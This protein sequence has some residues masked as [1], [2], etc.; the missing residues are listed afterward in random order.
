M[1]P[2]EQLKGI[3]IVHPTAGSPIPSVGGAFRLKRHG[4]LLTIIASWEDASGWDHVSVSLPHRCPT[5]DEMDAV[6]RRFFW[7]HEVVMQLHPAEA[8][9]LSLHP[10]CLHLWRPHRVAIPLPPKE[11]V[12]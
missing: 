1:R 4:T 7:P 2:Y 9:H 8:D 5:W 12:A 3:A 6:K 10:Y 11:F